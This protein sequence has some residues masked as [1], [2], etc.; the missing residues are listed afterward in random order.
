LLTSE[1][2]VI[3]KLYV[4]PRCHRQGIGSRLFKAAEQRIREAHF[5]ELF[6]GTIA[7]SAVPFYEKMGLSITGYKRG[8]SGRRAV[9]MKKPLKER[10][11]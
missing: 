1:L 8:R 4:D 5:S 10:T 11:P 3:T 7:D 9:L 2:R 6:L